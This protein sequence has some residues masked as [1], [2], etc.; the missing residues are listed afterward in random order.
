[1]HT[2]S[3]LATPI[4]D[5]HERFD[6]DRYD[7]F[8]RF[9]SF[10]SFDKDD[11]FDRSNRL[12]FDSFSS[13]EYGGGVAPYTHVGGL[14]LVFDE[15]PDDPLAKSAYP[16]KPTEFLNHPDNTMAYYVS[17]REHPSSDGSAPTIQDILEENPFH[18]IPTTSDPVESIIE[19]DESTDVDESALEGTDDAVASFL[20]LEEL[21]P[22]TTPTR[23]R[24]S[25]SPPPKLRHRVHSY[26]K[27][28][29]A[30]V[31]KLLR[32]LKSFTTGTKLF[33]LEEC[34]NEFH[35]AEGNYAFQDETAR[36]SMQLGPGMAVCKK[37]SL[38]KMPKVLTKP[39]MRRAKTTT[40]VCLQH[41]FP[42]TPKVM[43]NMESG[44]V[45]FQLNLNNHPHQ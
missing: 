38:S 4:S 8:N 15:L 31:G 24:A 39:E 20:D 21:R 32:K 42:S 7:S 22:D 18:D 35:I 26:S 17:F 34:L 44:L 11:G 27:L 5:K 14:Q 29:L 25:R 43:K 40:N 3:S 19:M 10:E 16:L 28:S 41:V 23:K 9:D 13:P 1:M 6:R 36:V 30:A 12:P 2:P 33:S 37:K 45:S